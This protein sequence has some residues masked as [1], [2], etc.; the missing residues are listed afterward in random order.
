MDDVFSIR[1]ELLIFDIEYVIILIALLFFFTRGLKRRQICLNTNL[2]TIDKEF[3]VCIKAVGCIFILLGHWGQRNNFDIFMPWGISKVVWLTTANIA[4]VWFM[5]FSG[6][7][8]SCKVVPQKEIFKLWKSRIIKIYAPLLLSCVCATI[9]GLIIEF[10]AIASV[11]LIKK[12]LGLWDWYVFCILIFYS[13]FYISLYVSNKFLINHTLLL[14]IFFVVYFIIAYLYFGMDKAHWFRYPWVFLL[15]HIVCIYRQNDSKIN[16]F[17]FCVLL[18]CFLFLKDVLMI[19]CSIIAV[20]FLCIFSVINRKYEY[21]GR[22]L[23]FLGGLSY[24][25]YLSHIRIGYEVLCYTRIDSICLWILIT[26]LVSYLLN[27]IY[28]YLKKMI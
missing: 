12:T 25:F 4:L 5:F 18:L 16:I 6:Y 23:L 19:C 26:V 8:L 13:L 24:F 3:T 27:V 7:G 14:T 15:G 10:D 22:V 17:C 20:V 9:M 1:S 21:R 28:L 11:S 2:L